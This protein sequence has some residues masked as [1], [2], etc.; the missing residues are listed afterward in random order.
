MDRGNR[1][2]PFGYEPPISETKGTLV[3]YDSFQNTTDLE[4]EIAYKV[5]VD[6]S[7]T[8]LVLYPL[9]EQT[10]KRLSKE[11]ISTL[12]KR[13][14][15]LHEWKHEKD[16]DMIV[17]DRLEAKRKKYTPLDSA[18]RHVA[19]TYPS[20]I[21][22]LLT[23]EMANAFASFTSFEPWISRIRLLLTEEPR[24]GSEH[25]NLLKH[26]NRWDAITLQ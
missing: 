7:F 19:E 15:R 5:A 21:F 17:I 8:K 2:V 16:T 25:P 9:H 23:P 10:M 26:R 6:R 12:Y 14:D 22:L 1:A 18:L 24:P 20:P 13:E 4:L 3:Y 11:P